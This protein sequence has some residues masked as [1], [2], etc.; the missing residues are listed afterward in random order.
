MAPTRIID[1]M[2]LSESEMNDSIALFHLLVRNTDNEKKPVKPIN[3]QRMTMKDLKSLF[4]RI[5][6]KISNEELK[7][8]IR[9]IHESFSSLGLGRMDGPVDSINFKQFLHLIHDE[10]ELDFGREQL[11]ESFRILSEKPSNGK[12]VQRG[13]IYIQDL[14]RYL[15]EFSPLTKPSENS[16][17]STHFAYS[18]SIISHEEYTKLLTIL[19]PYSSGKINYEKFVEMLI[20]ESSK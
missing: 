2:T 4:R 15:F 20:I 7:A 9:N 8:I 6:Y 5:G 1:A 11:L 3:Q 14:E 12:P 10:P 13:F 18:K 17:H 16:E 19:D